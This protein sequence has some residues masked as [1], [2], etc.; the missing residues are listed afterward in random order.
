MKKLLKISLITI[1]VLVIVMAG[2]LFT[3]TGNDLLK[4]FLKSQLEKQ[5]G[6]PVDVDLFKLRYD[7]VTLNIVV[8]NA[9][10]VK[11]TSLFNLLGLSFD[12]TYK[13]HANN[14]MYNKINFEKANINGEFKGVPDDIFVNG[15]GTS[16]NAPL[17]YY[18]RILEGEA[19]EITVHLKDMELADILELAKQPALAKGKVDANITIPTLVTAKRNAKGTFV[20]DGITFN[21]ELMKKVYKVSLPKAFELHGKVDANLTEKQIEGNVDM[22]SN[23]A[24]LN[25]QNVKFNTETKHM[26]AEYL[27]DIMNMKELSSVLGVKLDG[28]LKLEGS[29]EKTDTLKVTGLTHSLGGEINYS[30]LDHNFTSSIEAVPAQNML[31]MFSFPPFVGAKAS[32]KLNYDLSEMRGGTKLALEEFQI[33]PNKITK[34][35]GLLFKNDISSMQFGKTSLDAEFTEDEIFYTLMA[36][37]SN[38][39][40]EVGEAIINH[41][42]GIHEAKITFAYDKYAIEGSVEGS[43]RNPRIGFDT[44]GFLKDNMLDMSF[45]EKV[46]DEVKKF[47]KRF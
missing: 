34:S 38:A 5:V 20:F 12:G 43:L 2:I 29:V 27:A 16:F 24:N 25:L 32:G 26:N 14:F 46:E 4:P 1:P 40:V 44:K 13:I 8:N 39:S 41:E 7:N 10:N 47:F 37:A 3:Q 15:K 23:L 6:L 11:V 18:L 22:Y 33:A 36:K 9:L 31:K 45:A 17:N 19:K 21:D 42:K 35:L 30:L 28:A